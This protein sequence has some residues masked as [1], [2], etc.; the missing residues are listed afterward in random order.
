MPAVTAGC[1]YAVLAGAGGVH[2]VHSHS[3]SGQCLC[4][5]VLWFVVEALVS[6]D[7]V[8]GQPGRVSCTNTVVQGAAVAAKDGVVACLAVQ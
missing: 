1:H 7:L 2:S 4:L 8:A 6:S 5:Q 3:C